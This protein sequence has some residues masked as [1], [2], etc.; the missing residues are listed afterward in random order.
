MFICASESRGRGWS[1]AVGCA[2][3]R[4]GPSPFGPELAVAASVPPSPTPSLKGEGR[5][6]LPPYLGGGPGGGGADG[7]E[8]YVGG[9]ELMD[10]RG[11]LGDCASVLHLEISE[12]EAEHTNMFVDCSFGD[13]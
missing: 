13:S 3:A 9:E 8:G 11:M 6:D 2:W 5:G 4:R 1:G 7:P 10:Q 12:G